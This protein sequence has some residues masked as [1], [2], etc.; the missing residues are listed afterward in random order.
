[1]LRGVGGCNG[2]SAPFLSTNETRPVAIETLFDSLPELKA[3]IS[4]GFPLGTVSAQ[5]LGMTNK[6][7]FLVAVFSLLA[8][9][10][11]AKLHAALEKQAPM[12]YQDED[13]FHFGV[14]PA[15]KPAQWPPAA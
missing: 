7:S 11:L 15:R 5:L 1:M 13:G 2:S 10:L 9:T 3:S 14:E 12:G 6:T 8:A 4:R